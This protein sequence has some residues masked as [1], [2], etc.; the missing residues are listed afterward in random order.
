MVRHGWAAVPAARSE[1]VVA[2]WCEQA[3]LEPTGGSADA[4]ND[5]GAADD[6]AGADDGRTADEVASPVCRTPT[7]TAVSVAATASATATATHLA[8]DIRTS[9]LSARPAI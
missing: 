4:G 8:D 9:R 1:P 5:G 6:E 7:T 2:T 3:G